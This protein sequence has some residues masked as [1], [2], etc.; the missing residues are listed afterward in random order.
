MCIA[1]CPLPRPP[2]VLVH[3][4][5]ALD[6]EGAMPHL[7]P[8]HAPVL[9]VLLS[10][11]QCPPA[12]LSWAVLPL[13]LPETLPTR[14]A[15]RSG[16]ANGPS[17]R[18]MSTG[19]PWGG[20]PWR[21][22]PWLSWSLLGLVASGHP[23]GTGKGWMG[24]RERGHGS[25]LV[26]EGDAVCW[27]TGL[28]ALGSCGRPAPEDS[29]RCPLPPGLQLPDLLSEGSGLE[30]IGQPMWALGQVART[31]SWWPSPGAWSGEG[32]EVL[33][34][35]RPG[36]AGDKVGHGQLPREPGGSWTSLQGLAVVCPLLSLT[37]SLEVGAALPTHTQPDPGRGGSPECPVGRE[38]VGRGSEGTIDQF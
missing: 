36:A 3:I 26:E 7:P 14:A 34:K 38:P 21:A 20:G 32:S 11:P 18:G 1:R 22:A 29:G 19:S 8:S 9:A 23:G 12:F 10:F 37:F 33:L 6:L 16:S 31:R 15:A 4:S 30:F 25:D 27:E 17:C 28:L 24:Q 13:A 2:P 5:V 35:A